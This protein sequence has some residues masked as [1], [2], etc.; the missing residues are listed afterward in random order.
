MAEGLF[1]IF[2]AALAWAAVS[3]GVRYE[4]P[5]AVPLTLL[6]GFA[7][8]AYSSAVP[9]AVA[10]R[11]LAAGSVVFAGGAL[12]FHFSFLGGGDVKLLSAS[13]LWVGWSGLFPFLLLTAFI[14]GAFAVLL[15]AVRRLVPAVKDSAGDSGGAEET[16]RNRRWARLL[17]KDEGIPYGIPIALAGFTF[18][19]YARA[20]LLP[21]VQ[22]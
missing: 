4:I 1:Y 3:D 22:G 12:L 7:L 18:L 21:A 9:W 8:I 13:S 11:H 6:A 17:K 10:G 5:N 2:P 19:P 16:W 15:F 20:G 14:G